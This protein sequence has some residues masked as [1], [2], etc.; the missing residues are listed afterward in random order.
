MEELVADS[1]GKVK[2]VWKEKDVLVDVAIND[3]F[4]V[5][6]VSEIVVTVAIGSSVEEKFAGSVLNVISFVLPSSTLD[7]DE[8][9][10]VSFPSIDVIPFEFWCWTSRDVGSTAVLTDVAT[11]T[12]PP[13]DVSNSLVTVVETVVRV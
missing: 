4:E 6:R 9:F 7:V 2:D 3:S 5:V 12:L 13:C 1:L 8:K 11:V 10:P